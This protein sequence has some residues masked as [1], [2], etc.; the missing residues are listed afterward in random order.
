M[1]DRLTRV[2]IDGGSIFERCFV[3]KPGVGFGR[4]SEHLEVLVQFDQEPDRHDVLP[5]YHSPRFVHGG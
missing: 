2:Q 5:T 3:D 1:I 4:V